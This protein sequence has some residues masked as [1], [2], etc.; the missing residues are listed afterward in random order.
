MSNPIAN[1]IYYYT[2][3]LR[4]ENMKLDEAIFE[5]NRAINSPWPED[6]PPALREVL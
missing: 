4:V 2:R 6:L 3:K 5:L 1:R